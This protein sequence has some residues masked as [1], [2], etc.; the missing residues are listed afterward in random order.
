MNIVINGATVQSSFD[1]LANT[2]VNTA[3]DL[4]FPVVVTGGQITIQLVPVLGPAKLDAL[5]IAEQ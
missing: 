2:S 5:E 4:T 1:I 3:Y